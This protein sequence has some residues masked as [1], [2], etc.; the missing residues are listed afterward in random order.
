[1]SAFEPST[2]FCVARGTRVRTRAGEA[3]VEGLRVGD[4]VTAVDP[5]SGR[6]VS[7]RVAAIRA[8]RREC[9][10]LRGTTVTMECTTDHPL[11]DPLTQAFAVAGDWALGRRA[12]VLEVPEDDD[13]ALRVVSVTSDARYVTVHDVFDVTVEDALHTFVANGLLVGDASR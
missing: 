2:S 7:T 3:L 1:M 11:F 10:S 12:Q 6:R 13:E 9:L 8:S 4:E 5:M